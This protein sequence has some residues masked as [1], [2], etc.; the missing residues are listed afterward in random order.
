MPV[1]IHLPPPWRKFVNNAETV[2]V[3]GS[4]VGECLQNMF[5]TFPALQGAAPP[6]GFE[7]HINSERI[8][9]WQSDQPV[10]DGDEMILSSIS[11]C[12]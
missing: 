5:Q 8:F 6:T 4:T 11:G 9:S 7:I 2:E 3:N 1:K 10:K 12:C